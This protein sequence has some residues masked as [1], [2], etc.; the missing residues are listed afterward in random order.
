M[1]KEITKALQ[2]PTIIAKLAEMGINL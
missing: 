2:D 1:E